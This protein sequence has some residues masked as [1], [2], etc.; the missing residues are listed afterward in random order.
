M[1]PTHDFGREA[2]EKL[3]NRKRKARSLKMNLIKFG[4]LAVCIISIGLL[5]S[6]G[7]INQKLVDQKGKKIETPIAE[8]VSV[9]QKWEMPKELTEISGLS[10]IDKDRFACV[11][12]EIGTLYVFNTA[13]SKVEK[14]IAFSSPGDYEGLAIVDQIAW[15]LRADG[16]LLEI[17]NIQSTKPEV[18]EFSTALTIKHNPEGLCYDKSNNRLLIAI[19][20]A[21][22][23][24]SDYKGIYSFDLATK[25]MDVQPAFRIDLHHEVFTKMKQGKKKKSTFMPSGIV[26]HPLTGDMYITDGRNSLLLVTDKDGKIKQ[27]YQLNVN[28]FEQPEGIS[29]LPGGEIFIANEGTRLPGNILRIE[30]KK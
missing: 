16:K 18:K 23:N 4:V 9:V 27:L 3:A 15:V 26:L 21:E 24:S 22:P 11:Q 10:N 29:C 30:I 2:M 7:K 8:E 1:E 5:L 14:E 17:N 13:N 25:K 12:D 28:E 20:D 19:K 6:N